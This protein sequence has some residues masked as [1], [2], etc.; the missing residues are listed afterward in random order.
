MATLFEEQYDTAMDTANHYLDS[1]DP[2][3]AMAGR[4][5]ELILLDI[6]RGDRI[7][8]RVFGMLRRMPMRQEG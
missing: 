7:P 1:E 6:N 4:R 3:K 2:D 8:R 5:L